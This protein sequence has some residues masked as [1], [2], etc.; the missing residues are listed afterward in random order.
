MST[1]RLAPT[2]ALLVLAGCASTQMTSIRDP[3]APARTYGRILVIAPF[4]DLQ[5]RMQAEQ[6]FVQ[7]LGTRNIAALPSILSFPPTRAYGEPDIARILRDNQVDGILVLRLTDASTEQVYIP[8][9]AS[10]TG[11]TTVVGNTLNYSVQTQYSGGFFVSKPRVRFELRLLD[12]LIGQ[13]V[14]LATSLT[15]GE[16]LC[17]I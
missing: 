12:T 7:L 6:A 17:S 1:L 3:S 15:P 2:L 5:S 4:S 16:C 13:T 10:T 8:P 9:S 14:W 11:T